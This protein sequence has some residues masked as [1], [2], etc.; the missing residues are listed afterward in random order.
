MRATTIAIDRSKVSRATTGKGRANSTNNVGLAAWEGCASE[1]QCKQ[2]LLFFLLPFLSN[3][4]ASRERG[5]DKVV[6]VRES[7]YLAG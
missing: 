4:G 3:T 6:G 2:K 1:D 7:D 5:S